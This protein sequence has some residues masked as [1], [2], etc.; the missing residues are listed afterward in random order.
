MPLRRAPPTNRITITPGRP[1]RTA[2]AE[3]GSSAVGERRNGPPGAMGPHHPGAR[4]A[5]EPEVFV[6]TGPVCRPVLSERHTRR[7]ARQPLTSRAPAPTANT[8]RWS[9]LHSHTHAPALDGPRELK[10]DAGLRALPAERP[11]GRRGRAGRSRDAPLLRAHQGSGP[12][13]NGSIQSRYEPM[14]SRAASR[15]R[16]AARW[17]SPAGVCT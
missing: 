2:S 4:R 8:P 1:P 16:V 11:G 6:V 7:N 3:G 9:R 13:R 5:S 10:D 15:I 12:A 17:T 14:K